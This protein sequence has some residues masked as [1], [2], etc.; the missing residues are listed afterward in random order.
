MNFGAEHVIHHFVVGQSFWMRHLC[1][2]KAWAILE[3]NGTRVNDFGAVFSRAQRYYY[4]P[5]ADAKGKK[6]A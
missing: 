2:K 4:D 5:G 3:A 6:A 1:R